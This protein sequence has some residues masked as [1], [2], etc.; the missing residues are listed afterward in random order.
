[1]EEFNGILLKA[2]KSAEIGNI[3]ATYHELRKLPLANFCELYLKR[4]RQFASLEAFL[5]IMPTDTQQK[6]WVG[7]SGTT[8]MKRTASLARLYELLSW[9]HTGKGLQNHRLLDYG[10]G[11][12][13]ILSV[14]PYFASY[15]AIVGVD[16]LEESVQLC[17]DSGIHSDVC[18]I[19]ALPS[20]FSSRHFGNFDVVTIFSVFTHTPDWLTRDILKLC[21]FATN[22]TGVIFC[23]IRF[24]DWL[25]VRKNVWPQSVI[26]RMHL[27]FLETG[28]SFVDFGGTGIGLD[29]SLYGDTIISIA[30][31]RK[32]AQS[33]GWKI[34]DCERDPLEPFQYCVVLSKS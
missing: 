2:E 17:Q 33:A 3:D 32:L 22:D 34:V 24:A 13:R 8:L 1:M 4:P 21:A 19:T 10:C 31:F 16:P 20:E 23:T 9:K 29:H 18:L 30:S 12:G 14:M 6:Q 11:W 27:E 5:P 15:D 7:D 28:Y 25:L 26:D